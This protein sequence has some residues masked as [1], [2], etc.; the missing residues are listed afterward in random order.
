[1][2]GGGEMG[3]PAGANRTVFWGVFGLARHGRYEWVVVL[4]PP[5]EM[6]INQSLDNLLARTS[7][8]IGRSTHPTW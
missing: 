5:S 8:G 4:K 1:M 3:E 2:R 6:T 7:W